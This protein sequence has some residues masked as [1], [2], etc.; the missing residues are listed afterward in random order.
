MSIHHLIKPKSIAV[1][2]ATDKPG[3]F[4][5]FA[6]V[7]ACQNAGNVNVYLVNNKN[8]TVLGR[9]AYKSLA[10][11]PEVPDCIMVCTP[12]STIN[13]LITE[14]GEMGVKAAILVAAGYSEEGTE[15]GREATAELKKIVDHYGMKVMGPNCTGFVNNVDK[16]K[17]WGMGGTDFDMNT[18]KTGVAAFANS[19]TM[20]IHSISCPYLDISYS[21]SMGNCDFLSIEEILEEVVE[22]PEVHVIGIYLEGARNPG[23]LLECFARA[24]ELGKPVVIHAAGMSTKG[25]ASAASHTG[26][27][28]SSRRTYEAIFKKYGVIMVEN[29]DEYLSTLN[30][31]N[32]WHGNMPKH[33]KFSAFNSSGGENT[34][35]A[36]MAEKWGVPMYDFSP[37]TIKKLKAVLPD[38]ASPKNP[39]DETAQTNVDDNYRTHL[40][41]I[42]ADDPNVE[43]FIITSGFAEPNEKDRK[44]A[45]M[46]GRSMNDTQGIPII[47]YLDGEKALPMVVVPSTED[48]RD[49]EWRVKFAE[50]RVPILPS[51]NTGYNVLGKV[52]RYIEDNR[53]MRTLEHAVP[54]RKHGSSTIALTEID[55]KQE[56]REIGLPMPK[57]VIVKDKMNL[58]AAVADFNYPLVLKVSS[59]DIMHK[60]EAG[61]VKVGISSLED[62]QNAYDQIIDSCLAYKPE[63]NIEGILVQEMAD[64]GT[65]MIVG[66]TSDAKFGPMLMVGM[67]GV[68]VEVF[69]DVAMYPCPLNKE[70]ALEMIRSLKSYKLLTG[71]RGSKPCDVNALAD[72][73]VRVSRFAQEHKDEVKELDLN[74]VFVYPEGN[75]VSIVDA[76]LIKYTD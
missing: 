53:S 25:A 56:L 8:D 73:M 48:R 19:G 20:A 50:H 26:N 35:C 12:K 74:P 9:K 39:L 62:A 42:I 7:N 1:I 58:A 28:A 29:T 59:P 22:D 66:V 27:M 70:E 63:A 76:L 55:S 37:E 38:Y 51:S 3:S 60:T 36:D 23:K 49:N 54:E 6:A 64:P 61:G 69:Q 72:L 2:G 11:L 33:A 18:R 46:F 4:G 68:F 45:E 47:N 43:A 13:G 41:E 32:L 14:A 17:L 52:C 65:E 10:D 44:M 75:G 34:V 16:I 5:N 31:M 15:A 71:Y 40:Y 57:Q 30:L 21:F 67:G 24:N